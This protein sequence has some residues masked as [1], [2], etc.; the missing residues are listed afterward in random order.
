MAEGRSGALTRSPDKV[1]S[2]RTLTGAPVDL[3]AERRRILSGGCRKD[4]DTP[5]TV[6][7]LTLEKPVEAGRIIGAAHTPKVLHVRAWRDPQRERQAGDQF[8]LADGITRATTRGC[9]R[10]TSPDF[11]FH[12]GDEK[13]PWAKID[14]GTV[15]TVNAVEIEN[16][17]N[18]RRTEGLILSLSEDGQKWEEVWRAKQWESSWVVPVTHFD[19]GVNVPGV[20]RGSSRSKRKATRPR[21]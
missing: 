9:S 4:R 14:L 13:N 12:T 1:L 15:K 5:V 8:H 7:E 19:A 21:R 10:A 11:A 18:E 6:I 2:A 3:Q 16:R 20:R 17:P